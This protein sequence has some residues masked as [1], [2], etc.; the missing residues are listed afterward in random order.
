M[1]ETLVR[2]KTKNGRRRILQLVTMR[3]THFFIGSSKRLIFIRAKRTSGLSP[4]AQPCRKS[5]EEFHENQ[6][7]GSGVVDRRSHSGAN[8]DFVSGVSAR[9][10]ALVD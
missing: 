9:E 1:G 5:R 10:E 3:R 8:K 4:L 6:K 7:V 2:T